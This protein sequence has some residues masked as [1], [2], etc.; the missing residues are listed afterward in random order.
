MIVKESRLQQDWPVTL[1]PEQREQFLQEK[2]DRLQAW[3]HYLKKHDKS[4]KQN[5]ERSRRPR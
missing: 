2:V 3:Y 4:C 5:L 1:T